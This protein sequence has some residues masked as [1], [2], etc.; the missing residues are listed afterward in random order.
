MDVKSVFLNGYL[1][2]EVFVAQPK[3]FEDSFR[4]DHVYKLKKDFYGLKQAPKA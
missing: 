2:E 4:I 3:G 1:Y